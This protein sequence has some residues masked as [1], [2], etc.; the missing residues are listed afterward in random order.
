MGELERSFPIE[1][2]QLLQ[3]LTTSIGESENLDAALRTV[4]KQVCDLTDWSM[5]EVWIPNGMDCTLHPSPVWYAKVPERWE[6]FR[7]ATMPLRLQPGQGLPGR[8][9][10]T[11]VP[12]W[13][14][15][16]SAQTASQFVRL[17]LALS[18]GV[19]AGLAVPILAGGVAPGLK[20]EADATIQTERVVAVLAFFRFE[21]WLED[22]QRVNMVTAIAAQ[23]GPII[24]LKQTQTHLAASRNHLSRLIDSLPGIVFSGGNDADWS[25]QYLSAGCVALTG[26]RSEEL[27]GAQRVVSFNDITHPED[28]PQVLQAISEAI[29]QRQPYVVEYRIRTKQ[30]EEKWLWEKGYGVFDADGKVV[31][32]E[33]FITDTTDRKQM[34]NALYKSE[35]LFRNLF[36]RAA[37]GI[38]LNNREGKPLDCNAAFEEFLGYSCDELRTLTFHDWTYPEDLTEDIDLSNQVLAGD[39]DSFQIEKRYIRKDGQVVWG[40]LTVSAICDEAGHVTATF[41]IVEDINQRKQAEAALRA[42]EAQSHQLLQ[43]V[44]EMLF[45]LD[46]DGVYQYA[47]AEDEADLVCSLDRVLG[48]PIDQLLPVDLAQRIRQVMQRSRETGQCQTLEYHLSFGEELRY[49][50]ARIAPYGESAYVKTVRNVSKRKRTERAIQ[51]Q[52]AFLRLVLDAIP[53]HIFWKDTNLIYR[54]GNHAFAQSA[55]LSNPEELVGK[56]DADLW[57]PKQAEKYIARDRQILKTQQPIRNIIQQKRLS[58]G[59]VIWQDMDKVPIYDADNQIVGILGT[60]EDIT[61]Q[62]RI[63]ELLAR[64]QQYLSVVVDLQNVLLSTDDLSQVADRVLASLGE[65]ATASRAYLFENFWTAEGALR[66]RQIHE[67]CAEGIASELANPDLQ[68]MDY[69]Y[70]PHLRDHML[71]N[72][73]YMYLVTDL[74]GLEREILEPQG[75][76]SILLLPLW[77]NEQY[78]GFIGFDNCVEAQLW[79][80]MEVDLLRAAAASLSLSLER[81]QAIA[82]VRENEARYRLL[83]ENSNDVISRHCPQGI[84]RYASPACLTLLGYTPEELQGRSLFDLIHPSDAD[85]VQRVHQVIVRTEQFDVTPYCY[86]LRHKLGHYL[87]METCSRAVQAAVGGGREIISVSRDVT[88]RYRASELLTGQ[89]RLLEMIARDRPLQDT[90]EELLRL[91]QSQNAA[92]IPSI[93]LLNAE[94]THIQ[95]GIS[96]SLPQT[97]VEILKGL[98]I[99]PNVGTCGTAMYFGRTLITTDIRLDPLWE[100]FRDLVLP[101]GLVSCWSMPIFS[102]QGRILGSFATY[103][104]EPQS[105]TS[106]EIQLVEMARQIAAIAIEQKLASEALQRAEARYRGIFENA[107]EGIFQSTVDGHYTIVNPM[108]ASIYGYDSPEDLMEVLTDIGQQL[109]VNPRRRIEFIEEMATQGIVQGFE[110]QVYRKDGSIIWIS[111]C[112]RALLDEKGEIVGYEGTVENITLRKQAQD[113]LLKRDE[114]L[115]GVASATHQL[116]AEPEFD[117]AIHN[118]LQI[119]G[120]AARVDRAYIY[121][122][123][124]HSSTG[125]VA[126]SIRYEWTRADIAPT[127]T[128]AHWHDLPYHQAGL[129]KWYDCFLAGRSFSGITRLLSAAEQAIL[130]RDQIRSIIMV[131]IRIDQ[132]L[133]G[134]IGFDDC[135]T[136]RLW[137]ASEESML[138]AIA[139]SIGG[140]IQRQRTDSKMR[141]Q[142]FHDSLTGLPNRTFYDHR[143]T[144]TLAHARRA[145]ETVGV[146][147]LDFDR[148][149][150]INDTLGHAVGD[151]LLKLITQRLNN[152]LREED[153]IARWGGDEFTLLLPNLTSPED[154]AKVAQRIAHAL[155]PVFRLNGHDLHITCSL[156]IAIYPQDGTDPDTL[157]KNADVALYRAKEQGRNN[158]QFY[159]AALNSRA[160]ER[161]TLDHSLHKALEREELVLYYQPQVNLRTGKIEQIEALIRWQN[162]R[163]GL[164]SPQTFIPL[165]EENGLIIPI[166]DWVLETACKQLQQWHQ[167][168][169]TDLKLA[170]NLSVHQFQQPNLVEAIAHLIDTL[171]LNPHMLELEITETTF[172]KDVAF[173]QTLLHLLRE[174][175]ICIALDDFGTGYSSMNYLRELPLNTLKIDR[176]FVRDITTCSRAAA[177]IATIITLG[178]GLDLNVVAEGVETLEQQ[179]HL[180]SLHCFA[181]QGYLFSKPLPAEAATQFLLNPQVTNAS[182][183]A[184][185]AL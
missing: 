74:P 34:E 30:G 161:L 77:V 169:L 69:D 3:L 120:Q 28:L 132:E 184:P 10:Q 51:E 174:M 168:G 158:Y 91:I 49:F 89:K 65:L 73:T 166:G 48:Q 71:N 148:F 42:Q 6:S 97:Y 55:G 52:E 140:A 13:V 156:G 76:L 81:Q 57:E 56:T 24:Q 67:W 31:G 137:T 129:N 16:V 87:W 11:C 37:M 23:L 84:F 25:M 163:L 133:W 127:L 160:S 100:N 112:A 64:R 119:L 131:P 165:A 80:E 114:F 99:G 27:V 61:E 135:H 95:Q 41:G 66:A 108:L 60:Y 38:C 153:T 53:Q 62:R 70:V 151:Q 147:F 4:L 180:R 5:G 103:H 141:Y 36:D 152:C 170:V 125:A 110:S 47:Q 54:G 138:V 9:W 113:E 150:T 123:H 146:M 72:E 96:L 122:N 33:G 107:V 130:C 157:L 58:D 149:K 144:V 143:L 85:N 93:M 102:S 185:P 21:S 17:E 128:C 164:L 98:A 109:Y 45:V 15:D 46:A 79:H 182:A 172:M 68:N 1:M 171:A 2:T 155:K 162:P 106:H 82:A 111:E 179:E 12:E 136:E 183:A 59:R 88:E 117:Q 124:P 115:L 75:V 18:M 26:Y 154:A 19:K 142:A 181:M 159:T 121:Q 94:G 92:C 116:L 118:V 134:Y 139:A 20:T 167:M 178:Q 35:R 126:M 14:P 40:K 63:G 175:G 78:W 44:P 101:H 176:S 83:A 7:A 32:L 22:T 105:P 29:A 50:E 39:R 8:V 177:I 145:G 90:L 173:T 86:R 43:A 104:R